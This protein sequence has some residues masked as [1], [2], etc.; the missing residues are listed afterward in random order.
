MS[1]ASGTVN[2][3]AINTLVQSDK[4]EWIPWSEITDIES[5]Q[6]NSVYYAHV[7]YEDKIMLQLVRSN[8]ICTPT[9]VSEFAR[10]Y[11]LPTHKYSNDVSQFKS[12]SKWLRYRNE[13]IKG[14]TEYEG[15]YYLVAGREFYRYYSLHGFCSA[16][17]ILRCSP[18]W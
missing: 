2:N 6:I 4:L 12:Y 7:D 11:S 3:P 15:S 14:F 16:C 10:I 13:A 5:S 17:G 9:L 18:V 1:I 8:E